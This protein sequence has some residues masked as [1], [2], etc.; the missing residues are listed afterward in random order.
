[1][2]KS[3]LLS[4]CSIILWSACNTSTPKQADENQEGISFFNGSFEAAKQQAKKEK[5][6]IFLDVYASWCGPCKRLKSETFADPQV[7]AFYNE[8]FINLSI[9][10][11]EGEGSEIA[12]M[13]GVDSYPSL[14]FI[15]TTGRVIFHTSGF[16]GSEDFLA[17][18]KSIK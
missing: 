18:G 15:D 2:K 1:M 11:E 3:L 9:D 8:K 4:I 6:Y 17:L 14:F 16:H 5:K 7:A 13:Y 12:N 10:A